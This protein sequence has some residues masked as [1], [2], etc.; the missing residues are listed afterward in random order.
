MATYSPSQLDRYLE[1]INLPQQAFT[2]PHNGFPSELPHDR[3]AALALLHTLVTHQLATVPFESLSL[4]YSPTHTLSL[5]PQDLFTKIVNRRRGGYCMEN[6]TFFGA[7]LRTIGFT[8]TPV[9]GRVS[10][11][12]AGRPGTGYM[13]WN[14]MVN[15]V[16]LSTTE[17]GQEEEKYLVDVGFGANGPVRP[18]LLTPG[19]ETPAGIDAVR[20]KLRYE[21]LPQHT[22]RSQRMWI[23]S[24]RNNADGK[25]LD[26]YAF[27][28]MEFLPDDFA[29]MN[30]ATSTLRTS[31]F[32]QSLFCVR[33][34]VDGEGK[35]AGWTVLH[36][37]KVT[38]RVRGR[39][40]AEEEFKSEEQRVDA[41]QRWFGI[42]LDE[43]EKR[44]IREL[45]TEIRGWKLG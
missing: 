23:Y 9:G 20:Y 2:S 8:V 25:W 40:E 15:L 17:D 16:T 37:D 34:V 33:M 13:G 30:L 24:Y 35:P 26:A 27:A 11:A 21:A 39:V 1:H 29:V 5:H 4:H 3:N 32:V 19:Q 7:I 18:L 36:G 31:F 43:V 6:N 45:P 14:H 42:V 12:T 10:H 44:G 22:D 28:E 41:L 38:R